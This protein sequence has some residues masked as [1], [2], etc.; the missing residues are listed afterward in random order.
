MEHSDLRTIGV[1]VLEEVHI[2]RQR[3]FLHL[4]L[5]LALLQKT[6][7]Q[8]NTIDPRADLTF[9]A[10][11]TDAFPHVDQRLLKEVVHFLFV[12]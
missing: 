8:G 1:V 2:H 10:K 5:F 4:L 11:T 12:L 7:V 9:F 6:C 3:H